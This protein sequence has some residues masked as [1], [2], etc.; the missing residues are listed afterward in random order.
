MVNNMKQNIKVFI[1]ALLI[2]IGATYIF[3]Y[4]YD[5][6][7]ISKALSSKVTYFYTGS[8]TDINDALKKQENEN[9]IIYNDSGIYKVVIGVYS[10]KEVIDLMKTYYH[11]NN[12]NFYEDTLKIDNTF[13]KDIESYELLIKSSSKEYYNN[14]NNSILN[15]FN[16]YLNK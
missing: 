4:K 11:D 15:I 5:N 16:E 6:K 10:K 13:I 2:G 7:I 1:V 12:I 14:L 8:Y 9:S 3:A